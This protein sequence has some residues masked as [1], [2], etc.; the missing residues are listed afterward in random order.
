[1]QSALTSSPSSRVETE[2]RRIG[3]L[4]ERGEFAQSLRAAQALQMEVPENRDVLYMLAVSQRHMKRISAALETLSLLEKHHPSFSRLFQERGHCNVAMNAAS[5]AID[6]YRHAVALNSCLAESW[7]ALRALYRMLGRTADA[8]FA[9]GQAAQLATLPAEIRTAFAMFADGQLVVA[10]ELIRR[11]LRTHGEHVEGMRLLA[12]IAVEFEVDYDAQVLLERVLAL[13]PDH[14]V[15]RHELALVL[16]KRQRHEQAREQIAK[17]LNADPTSRAYRS[18]YAAACSG[19]GDYERALPLQRELAAETPEEPEPQLSIAHSLK[20]L[21][22][23][24]E[25]IETYRGAAATRRSFGDAYWSLANLKIY[26]F[27]D[28]ELERMKREEASA[29]IGLADRY[30][31][32]FALGK[33]LEDRERYAESFACYVRGNS[34]KRTEVRY[35]R[36]SLE[37]IAGLQASI[38][39]QDF[40]TSRRNFG[41]KSA[42]P[43]FIVGL[44]RSG[45]TLIEQ[46]LA[47]HSKVDGTMELADIPRLAQ[48]LQSSEIA[49]KNSGYPNL[50]AD[51]SAQMCEGMGER[52]L[53]D[54][55]AYRQGKPHFVDKMPNNFRYLDLIHL[56][57]PNAKILDAR[58]EPMAC[59]WSIFK[60][61]FAAGQQFAYDMDDVARY[62]RLYV[63]LMEHWERALPGKILRVQH[64]DVVNDLESNVR[65]ILDFCELEFEPACLE[66]HRT[67]R[68]VHS[69]SSEQVHQPVYRESIDQWRHFEPWLAPLKT[70]LGSLAQCAASSTE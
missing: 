49:G 23:T 47:S 41:C 14:Q 52:Y 55:R 32:C 30:H 42:A 51:L 61:L 50:L 45:S 33:A 64:E 16:L 67:R 18:I 40:F 10:E 15:A 31:L 57:L 62:Y 25:A 38:C 12:K 56:I 19:L 13:A 68:I 5:P 26:R 4:M 66:F 1:M 3:A 7:N 39:T 28:E 22:R 59:C 35:R 69:A 11:Y 60:Q 48:E 34:L 29:T 53:R 46:I 70:A 58:R 21:G 9:A 37:R 24:S 43:L 17:L 65:R 2:V 8:E 36:E 27:T 44:P 63:E 6:A 54:T 20:T